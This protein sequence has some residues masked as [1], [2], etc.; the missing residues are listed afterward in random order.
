MSVIA[1]VRKTKKQKTKTLSI[2]Y[3]SSLETSNVLTCALPVH[4][5]HDK[6]QCPRVAATRF[7]GR[8]VKKHSNILNS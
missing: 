7:G 4:I 6:V 3:N 2:E 8:G 1:V 5:D